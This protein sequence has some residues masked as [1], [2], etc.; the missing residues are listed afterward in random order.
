VGYQGKTTPQ[1]AL[2]VSRPVG[3]LAQLSW[4]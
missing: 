4:A 2:V 1:L 3:K